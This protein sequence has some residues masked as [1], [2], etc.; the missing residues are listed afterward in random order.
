[1]GTLYLM[2]SINIYLL[3]WA[4]RTQNEL[5]LLGSKIPATNIMYDCGNIT[6]KSAISERGFYSFSHLRFTVK[7]DESIDMKHKAQTVQNTIIII[8]IVLF[9]CVIDSN[10]HI[11]GIFRRNI[12]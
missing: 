7:L 10:S 4:I 12:G 2:V 11:F 3:F 5:R 8:S 6:F 1:M 9:F